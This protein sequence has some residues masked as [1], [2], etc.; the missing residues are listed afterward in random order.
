[1]R[2]RR[3]GITRAVVV[4][5]GLPAVPPPADGDE[6]AL[7]EALDS[8]DQAVEAD[9]YADLELVDLE[10]QLEERATDVEVEVAWEGDQVVVIA[11]GHLPGPQPEIQMISVN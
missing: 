11:Q 10:G 4:V 9:G 1:M 2:G 7:V 6:P 5:V 3:G 8:D